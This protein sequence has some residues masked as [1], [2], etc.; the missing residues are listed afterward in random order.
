MSGFFF[1][2]FLMWLMPLSFFAYQFVLRQWPSLTMTDIMAHFQVDAANF[3][4]FSAAYYIGYAVMQIPSAI[5][6]ERYRSNVLIALFIFMAVGSMAL[7]L[8]TP[9]WSLAI[10]ARFLI[11]AASAMGFLSVSFIIST[12]F[13]AKHYG[14]MVGLSFSFGL[15]GAV[16]GGRPVS[17]LIDDYGQHEAGMMIVWVGVALGFMTL[18]CLRAP[19]PIKKTVAIETFSSSALSALFKNRRLLLLGLSNLL[20]VGALE[21]F[22]DIWGVN[23]LSLAYD[24]NKTDGAGIISF[25]FIGMLIGGP[26][27]AFLAE[28]IGPFKVISISGFVM[29]GL[30]LVILFSCP[31][32]SVH[33]LQV[34]LFGIGIFCCYQVIVF[35]ACQHVVESDNLGLSV[36]FLNGINMLG[37]SFFHTVIGQTATYFWDGKVINGCAFYS[38]E[39]LVQSLL[40]IP[41]AALIGAMIVSSLKKEI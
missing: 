6:L 37:G 39:T 30:F 12:W 22:A 35:T 36:A 24:I 13:K 26:I 33:H 34:V 18:F 32:L 40:V 41:I 14:R 16:Y 21:G 4:L 1:R 15:L 17:V 23:F 9:Y 10:I 20:L 29:A 27:L 2:P 25:I 3:G 8:Y 28:R 5:L 11:G 38:S 7:L 19:E 31:N